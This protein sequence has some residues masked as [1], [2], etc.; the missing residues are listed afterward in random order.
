[1]LFRSAEVI[2]DPTMLLSIDKWRN[3]SR[4]PKGF[5]DNPYILTYFLSSKCDQASEQLEKLKK[6]NLKVYEIFDKK[7]IVTRCAGPAEFLYLID[8]A[9][10]ILTDS[11]HAS[12]F[13]FLFNKPFIVYDR[14]QTGSTMNSRLNTFLKKFQ[15][16]RK[17]AMSKLHQ[18]IWEHD[19]SVGYEQ[20]NIE[21][22]KAIDFLKRALRDGDQD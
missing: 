13:S 5:K 10:I 4:K 1:M 8:H 7:N 18:N 6:E 15:I 17:Y 20:L 21:K 16:E 2:V 12:V 19:Y 11:F 22:K 3:V 9:S 14:N